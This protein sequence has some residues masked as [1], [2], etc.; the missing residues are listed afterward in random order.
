MPP[1]PNWAQAWLAKADHDLDAARHL[2]RSQPILTDIVG[3]HAQ[4]AAEKYLMAICVHNSVEFQKVH[5]IRYLIDLCI[6]IAPELESLRSRAE[7][8]TRYA[9]Q[10]RYPMPASEDTA[11]DAESAVAAAEAVGDIAV[12]HVRESHRAD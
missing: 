9:V 4:Q 3:F 12:Q 6:E 11:A 8:L 1:E 5:T 2:L 7:P 10:R